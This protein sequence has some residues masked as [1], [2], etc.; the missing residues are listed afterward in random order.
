[1]PILN[2]ED[3]PVQV[4]GINNDRRKIYLQN[5]GEEKIYIKKKNTFDEVVTPSPTNY[6]FILY[7]S[8]IKDHDDKNGEKDK[9]CREYITSKNIYTTAG[10]VAVSNQ[11]GSTLA[12]MEVNILEV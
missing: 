9:E 4:V 8:E 3:T 12:F 6:D 7:P 2:I 10:F 11:E 1:M 5:T